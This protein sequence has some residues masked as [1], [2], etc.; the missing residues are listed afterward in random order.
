[1]SSTKQP[2]QYPAHVIEQARQLWIAGEFVSVIAAECRVSQYRLTR[3][4]EEY[5]WPKRQA[6]RQRPPEPEEL[7]PEELERRKAS[8]REMRLTLERHDG[9]LDATPG[10]RLYAYVNDTFEAIG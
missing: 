8:V 9:P 2:R 3:W 4:C 6:R 7:S 5:G 1:M 10:I